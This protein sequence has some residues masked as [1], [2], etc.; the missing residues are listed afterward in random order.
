MD[1]LET[2]L[3]KMSNINKVQQYFIA[4]LMRLREKADYHNLVL[5]KTLLV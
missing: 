4:I 5:L 3:G 2:I 1:I